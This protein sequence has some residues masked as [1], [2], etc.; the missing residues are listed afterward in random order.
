[1]VKGTKVGTAVITMPDGRTVEYPLETGADVAK[2]G[3]VRRLMTTAR[4]YLVGWL[5]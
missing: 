3:I 1:V 4:H 5:S 2:L